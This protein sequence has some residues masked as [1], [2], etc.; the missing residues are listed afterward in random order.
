[1]YLTDISRKLIRSAKGASDRCAFSRRGAA[2]PFVRP[3][4][5]RRAARRRVWLRRAMIALA[6]VAAAVL[7]RLVLPPTGVVLQTRREFPCDPVYFYQ[8][9]AAWSDDVIGTSGKTI[10]LDGDDVCCLASLMAMQGI[11]APFDGALNPGTLNAWLSENGG[12]YADGGL[13]WDRVAELMGAKLSGGY[14][15]RAASLLEDLIQRQ[16]Y[17]VVRVKRPDTGKWHE[18]LIVGSVHGEFT[19][20]DPLDPT[21]TLNTMGLYQNRIYDLRYLTLEEA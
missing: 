11:P 14:G 17:A 15:A 2:S 16:V 18:V 7:V 20:V 8:Q 1:M 13:K 10:G 9:D 5:R 3:A 4:Y 19:I 12:Y 21:G 6:I